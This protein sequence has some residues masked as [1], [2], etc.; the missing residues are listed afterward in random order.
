MGGGAVAADWN[1]LP[2]GEEKVATETK[3]TAGK[4]VS[5]RDNFE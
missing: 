5:W 4:L 2:K 1:R 3:L